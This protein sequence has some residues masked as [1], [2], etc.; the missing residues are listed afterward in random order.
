M[1][2][3]E[4]LLILVKTDVW[5]FFVVWKIYIFFT[6]IRHNSGVDLIFFSIYLITDW[7]CLFFI[8]TVKRRTPKP[9]CEGQAA[10]INSKAQ[11]KISSRLAPG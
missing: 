3:K 10:S 9:S 6:V 1:V 5:S 7:P 2:K 4:Q 11:P 8:L